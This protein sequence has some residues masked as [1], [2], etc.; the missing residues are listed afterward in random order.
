MRPAPGDSKDLFGRS[1]ATD[2]PRANF[3]VHGD[4]DQDCAWK[5]FN[6]YPKIDPERDELDDS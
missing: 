1:P 3:A 6:G 2:D 5:V 4:G